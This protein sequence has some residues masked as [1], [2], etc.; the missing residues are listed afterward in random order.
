MDLVGGGEYGANQ[1]PTK[2]ERRILR[3]AKTGDCYR[4]RCFR[5]PDL[6]QVW[7]TGSKHDRRPALCDAQER[8]GKA[9][10]QN[11]MGAE[12]SELPIRRLERKYKY[13]GKMAVAH[14]DNA[15]CRSRRHDR[16]VSRVEADDGEVA[17]RGE[18]EA[19][20]PL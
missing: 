2:N 3:M 18:E 12:K 17:K 13:F 5:V 8:F 7:Y 14:F 9:S 1:P 16:W 6:E 20:A 10:T 4:R 15:S 19:G 11:N